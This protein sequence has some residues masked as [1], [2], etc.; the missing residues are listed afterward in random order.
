[1]RR[2]RGNSLRKRPSLNLRFLCKWCD[3]QCFCSVPASRTTRLKRSAD[4]YLWNFRIDWHSDFSIVVFGMKESN[5]SNMAVFTEEKL[6]TYK[7]R[8]DANR[9]AGCVL[10]NWPAE[11][12]GACFSSFASS[13]ALIWHLYRLI[14]NGAFQKWP[15]WIGANFHLLRYCEMTRAKG[16]ERYD[17]SLLNSLNAAFTLKPSKI[18]YCFH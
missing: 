10:R 5:A 8:I 2:D 7:T 12:C 6:V 11:I 17:A 15:S 3:W 16:H 18:A 14:N 4:G 1:M 13:F 9:R